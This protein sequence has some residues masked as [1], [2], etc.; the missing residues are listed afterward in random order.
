ME[1]CLLNG[2][3][4]YSKTKWKIVLSN[5][6]DDYSNTKFLFVFL[7]GVV[8]SKTTLRHS[9]ILSYLAILCL[10]L[11]VLVLFMVNCPT[12]PYFVLLP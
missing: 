3:K 8:A 10:A 4:D 11:V 2:I 5:G 1:D 12:F 7:P 9:A 6:V